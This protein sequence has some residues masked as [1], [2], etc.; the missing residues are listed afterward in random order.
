MT[1]SF[2][3]LLG[4]T[5]LFAAIFGFFAAPASAERRLSERPPGAFADDGGPSLAIFPPQKLTLRFNHRRH[6]RDLKLT[7]TTCHERAKTSQSSADSL[8][9]SGTRCDGCHGSNHT[10]ENHVQSDASEPISQCEFC[11]LG[12][13]PEQ[14]N[15]VDPLVVP[16]P[17][18]RFNHRAHAERNIGCANCHGAVESVTLATRD[19]LPRMRGCFR[20]HQMPEPSRGDARGACPTC[21]LTERGV[22]KTQFLGRKLE[23]PRWLHN[24]EHGPDWLERHKVAAG[25]ESRFCANCHKE[26]YCTACHDGRVRPRQ[27]HPNDFISMHPI[28]ARQNNPTCQSCHRSQ[29][30]CVSCH[31][32]AGITMTGPYGNSE[33]RGRFHPP[34]AVWTDPPRGPGHH[35]W[36]AQRNLNACVSCHIE[37]DCA[38]CHATARMGGRGAGSGSGFGQGVNPHPIGFRSRCAAALRKNARPCLVC[39]EPS[40]PDLLECR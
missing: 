5:C 17:N 4:V 24:A 23:P 18:L 12:Y 34:R 22:L 11:H 8:L 6:V 36:E 1:R 21:H 30:F 2:A 14:G 26:E 25:T 37:R 10:H 27:V 31:Q 29:S 28:A 35:A 39:H 32:R 15:R 3:W 7:C 13:R 33:S 20:C 16:P 19:Q 9:P 40:D 38:I